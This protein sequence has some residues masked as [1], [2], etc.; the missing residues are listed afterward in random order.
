MHANYRS[1]PPYRGEDL[2]LPWLPGP[3]FRNY[4]PFYKSSKWPMEH[5]LI[6]AKNGPER[7]QYDIIFTKIWGLV[8]MDFASREL[9]FTL[10]K[11]L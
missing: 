1:E 6:N 5:E 9:I 3:L 10:G 4:A 8:S 11:Y 2:F 7:P